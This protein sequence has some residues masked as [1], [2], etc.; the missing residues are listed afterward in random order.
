[1]IIFKGFQLTQ[2]L[3]FSWAMSGRPSF[4]ASV[5][6]PEV[7][8]GANTGVME[9][10]HVDR[11]RGNC[12]PELLLFEDERRHWLERHVGRRSVWGRRAF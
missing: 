11:L 5:A 10:A 2:P 6:E 12:R 3:F 9:E 1:M 4:A 7:K 8:C